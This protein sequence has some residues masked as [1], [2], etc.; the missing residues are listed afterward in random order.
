[1]SSM[2]CG[3]AE[4]IAATAED[5]HGPEGSAVSDVTSGRHLSVF[6]WTKNTFQISELALD[7]LQF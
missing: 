2:A 5:C 4:P 1:M 6:M 3:P 7:F